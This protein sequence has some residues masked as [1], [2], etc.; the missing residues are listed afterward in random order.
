MIPEFPQSV[1]DYLK[2][3]QILNMMIKIAE[4]KIAEE[5]EGQDA[6]W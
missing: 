3:I 4:S 1:Q 2:I 5:R 6:T